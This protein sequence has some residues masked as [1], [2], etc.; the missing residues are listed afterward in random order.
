VIVFELG[1]ENHHRFEGWFASGEDFDRQLGEKLLTCPICGNSKITRLPH[2][3]YVNTGG[4]E[5]VEGARRPKTAPQQYANLGGEALSR[6]IN[7]IIEHTDDVGAAFPE[8]A[9]KIHYQESPERHIRGTASAKEVEALKEEG[10]EV[11]ALPIPPHLAGK[12]H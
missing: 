4:G 6:L 8:E 1:C 2:A 10:I 9:R 12:T 3:S 5:R 7:H 11:V